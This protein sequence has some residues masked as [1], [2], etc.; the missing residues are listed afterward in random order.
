MGRAHRYRE[1]LKSAEHWTPLL[2]GSLPLA[3]LHALYGA[4]EDGGSGGGAW[5]GALPSINEARA[6]KGLPPLRLVGKKFVVDKG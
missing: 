3:Q 5:A 2:L 1:L 4:T 6:A